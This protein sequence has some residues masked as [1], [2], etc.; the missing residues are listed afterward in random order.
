MVR[1]ITLTDVP[2]SWQEARSEKRSHDSRT[3]GTRFM[4]RLDEPSQTIL[5]QLMTQFGASR[6]E[7]ICQ[8][9]A[10]ARFPR[11]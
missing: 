3:Y 10:Q 7:I 1:Q 6:A 9:I 4:R 11:I 5:Q 8:L 2:A